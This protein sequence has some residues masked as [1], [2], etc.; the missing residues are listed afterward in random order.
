M[1]TRNC[2]RNSAI[3]GLQLILIFLLSVAA[4]GQTDKEKLQKTKKQLEDEIRYTNDLLEKTKQSKQVSMER[5]KILNQRIRSREALI[6]TINTELGQIDMNI[7]VENVELDR[8]SQ[9]L[10][11]LKTDYAR[12]ICH[13]YRTMNGR[14]KLMF[15]FSAKDFN[16]AW[17]RIKYYQ[18]YS[19]YRR[20]QAERI[21]STTHVIDSQRKDLEA[22]KQEKLTLFETQQKE[23]VKLDLEKQDKAKTVKELSSKEKQLIATL[24]TKQQAAARLQYEI[25]KLISAE[26]SASE[27]RMRR[28]EGKEKKP[29]SHIVSGP[30]TYEMTPSERNLSS[31]F[32]ANRGRLPWPCDRGFISGTFGEHPHPVLERVKVKNN[33]VDITTQPNAQVKAV[34]NG[35]VSKIMSFPNLNNVVIVRHGEYLTVY[36][37]LEIVSVKEGQEVT[38]RQAIGKVQTNVDEQKTE[39]HFEIWK[40]KIIQNPE[41]WLAG[42]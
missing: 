2:C 13:A 21:E 8:M 32:A 7:Q 18:Q 42:R 14:N 5:L 27:E 37:N 19:E 40:G 26:I 24:K 15:I 16:Q 28:S 17:Q 25:E 41:S 36:S 33:G 34:F 23:K 31:S 22:K 12:M 20:R 30:A 6:A 39:L 11:A 35:K 38:T 4:F 1:I 10:K 9:Q 3:F 29:A